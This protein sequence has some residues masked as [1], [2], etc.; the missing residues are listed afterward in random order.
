MDN[1]TGPY[2]SDGKLQSSVVFGSAM[3]TNELDMASRLH[4]TAYATYSA[5][6]QQRRAADFIYDETV[7]SLG[8]LGKFAG[9]TVLY[10]NQLINASGELVNDVKTGFSVAG[11]V[12]ALIGG[13]YGAVKNQVSVLDWAMNKEKYVK[14]VK[15]F[16]KSDPFLNVAGY[17]TPKTVNLPRTN[18]KLQ[19]KP[20]GGIQSGGAGTVDVA[21]RHENG[22]VNVLSENDRQVLDTTY[23]VRRRGRRRYRKT[24]PYQ[25]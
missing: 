20:P 19:F 16:Y 9:T 15:E 21:T 4:D 18:D 24:K 17:Q 6:S 25:Y 2:W 13:I 14:E 1:Y 11:P 8:G 7:K 22:Y 5:G 3:P 12:G 10:G 23:G